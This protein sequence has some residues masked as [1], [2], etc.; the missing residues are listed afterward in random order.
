MTPN[1]AIWKR[2]VG[3]RFD[4]LDA[5]FDFTARLARDNGWSRPFA[6]R[7]VEEYRRFAYLAIVTGREVTPSDEVDQAWHLHLTYTRH[8]WGPFA[9]AL[10]APLHHNPTAGGAKERAR[11]AD[12]YTAT[13]ASYEAAFGEAP[14]A[15]IWPPAPIRFGDAPF[16]Q[17][18]NRRR[19][20]VVPKP[21]VFATIGA[22]AGA[23]AL[24]ASV[25]AQD[26]A[27]SAKGLI[28][29]F[30][31]NPVIGFGLVAVVVLLILMAINGMR[32]RQ[33]QKP[34]EMAAETAAP[35]AGDAAAVRPA[36]QQV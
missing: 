29:A 1:D 5:A 32:Q 11:Y 36:P 30:N 3:L 20:Y 25:A 6:G 17:R 2:L 24:T 12:N 21:R 35:D 14:P 10:G 8:Y 19:H 27:V 23:A 28:D 33:R 15:D 26:S 34:T 4:D 7:V 22:G 9:E 18:V 16:M 13:L 31:D